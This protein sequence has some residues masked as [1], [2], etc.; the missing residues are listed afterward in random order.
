MSKNYHKTISQ[1]LGSCGIGLA[2]KSYKKLHKNKNIQIKK[3]KISTHILDPS[4]RVKIPQ[5]NQECIKQH[6]AIF[7][8][9]FVRKSKRTGVQVAG[10][11]VCVAINS[12][13]A[14]RKPKAHGCRSQTHASDGSGS[15]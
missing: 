3:K 14:P 13:K 5:N 11:E 10:K 9:F 2:L 4:Q 7:R 8:N 12:R 6:I 15:N 1:A